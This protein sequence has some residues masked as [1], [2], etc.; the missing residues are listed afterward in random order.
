MDPG[1][2]VAC[3]AQVRAQLLEIATLY[4]RIDERK[5]V[6]G[7]AGLDSLARQLHNLYSA[8]EGLFKIVAEACENHADADAG[9]HTSL[10]RRMHVTVPGVRPAAVSDDALPLLDNLRRFRH[11]VRHAYSAEIDERQLR[12]VLE[13][14]RS[15]RPL[16][17]RDVEALLAELE[18]GGTVATRAPPSP[19]DVMLTVADVR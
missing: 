1:R 11:V 18:P 19:R 7:P 5:R 9:Y 6:P 4:D 3:A 14:A 16:L 13:D 12:I 17:W 15:L 2:H 10:L 8:T